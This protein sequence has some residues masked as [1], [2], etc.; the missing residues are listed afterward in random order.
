MTIIEHCVIPLDQSV[1][2]QV[3]YTLEIKD[4]DNY[5]YLK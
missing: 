2:G 3:L 4:Y 5:I 1:E